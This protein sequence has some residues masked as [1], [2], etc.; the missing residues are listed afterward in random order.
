MILRSTTPAT[1]IERL[2]NAL[3]HADAIV[4]GAGSG[5]S[6]SA[7]FTYAG[8]R[9]ER[10]FHDF[11]ERYG[12]PDMYSGGFW[13]YPDLETYWA[14]WS[15][16]IYI[17]RYMDPPRDTYG[18]LRELVRGKDFFVITT[19]VDHCFQKAGFPDDR[20][21]FTQGDYGLFQ[22]SKPGTSRTYSNEQDVKRMLVAQGFRFEHD[23]FAAPAST[24]DVPAT[25]TGTAVAADYSADWGALLPPSDWKSIR[26]AIPQELIPHCPE[27]GSPMQP[28][29][30]SDETFAEDELWHTSLKRYEAFLTR[31]RATEKRGGHVLFLDLGSGGNTPGIFK[32]PF[33]QWTYDNANATYASINLG[34]A[35]TDQHIAK[36][37]ILIDAD[38]DATLH[39]LQGKLQAELQGT[40]SA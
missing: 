4:I 40:L 16:S 17:N 25:D 3:R 33:M 36:R 21:F 5:L 11:V 39:E 10:Y 2:A 34:E 22:S 7:G 24:T 18:L 38:I 19:N 37:S 23:E 31:T 29:L 14:W 20:L 27:D 35:V 8:E 9:L 15:R 13:D 6:T 30:R 12:I 28:N 1:P 26:M 32:Y